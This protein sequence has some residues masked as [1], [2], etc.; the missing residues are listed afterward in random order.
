M[1]KEWWDINYEIFPE[2]DIKY[3]KKLVLIIKN[4]SP[5]LRQFKI[6]VENINIKNQINNIRFRMYLDIINPLVVSVDKYK[7]AVVEI[8]IPRLVM[9]EEDAKIDIF[10]ENASNNEKKII[11]VYIE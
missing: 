2:T 8:R 11:S 3:S 5:Y 7:K 6:G 9:P 1:L 4:H 10:V